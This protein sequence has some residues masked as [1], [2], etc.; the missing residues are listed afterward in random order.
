MNATFDH[1]VINAR[2][3][4][5]MVTFYGDVLGFEPER[6]ELYRAGEAPFPSV[7][8][9]AD[10]IID[11]FPPE[12]WGGGEQSET[13]L[14]HFCLAMEK[15]DWDEL[16]SRL[17]AQGV[18]EVEGPVPRWG[19]HGRGISVYFDDPEGNRIEARYYPEEAEEAPCKLT[20]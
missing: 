20:S 12:L 14:N 7:R 5:A 10:S 18:D 15:P 19:A 4:D 13:R 16:R 17:A 9:N 6:L 3:V 2:N 1:I 8:F 11:L